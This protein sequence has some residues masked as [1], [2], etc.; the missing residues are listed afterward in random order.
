M[1]I[2]KDG[3]CAETVSVSKLVKRTAVVREESK[4]AQHQVS[5]HA[6]AYFQLLREQHARM[7]TENR[8]LVSYSKLSPKDT[9]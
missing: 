4:V 8:S 6:S 1:F 7:L 9:Q 2:F 3:A 5:A